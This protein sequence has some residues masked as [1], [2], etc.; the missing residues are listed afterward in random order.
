MFVIYEVYMQNI[1]HILYAYFI[2]QKN[3]ISNR[4]MKYFRIKCVSLYAGTMFTVFKFIDFEFM[5]SGYMVIFRYKLRGTLGAVDL[6][7]M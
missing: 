5:D 6:Y 7:H 1:G 4:E 3:F 2:N